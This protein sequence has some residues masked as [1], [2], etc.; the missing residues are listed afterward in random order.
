MNFIK[1]KEDQ[2]LDL[3]K[4]ESVFVMD[5]PT[6]ENK[7][8]WVLVFALNTLETIRSTPHSP[9]EDDWETA[10]NKTEEY[11]YKSVISD[12]FPTYEKACKALDKI[13]TGVSI[14]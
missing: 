13:M 6:E 2:I 4:V 11:E 9:D 7:I 8:E 14:V 1:I 5:I 12:S 10:H 3:D